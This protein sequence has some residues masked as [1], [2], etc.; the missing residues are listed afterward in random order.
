[1]RPERIVAALLAG[2]AAGLVALLIF[3]PTEGAKAKGDRPRAATPAPTTTAPTTIAT[4]TTEPEPEETVESKQEPT[5]TEAEPPSF[6][7]GDGTFSSPVTI[8]LYYESEINW[9]TH[10]L[11]SPV[12]ELRVEARATAVRGA[13]G[14]VHGIE[15]GLAHAT[16]TFLIDPWSGEY[17]VQETDPGSLTT[18]DLESGEAATLRTPPHPNVLSMTCAARAKS[19]FL[20]LR[21]NGRL[22]T[23]LMHGI[24][25]R[26][27]RVSVTAW[28]PEGGQKVVFDGV[29]VET[30]GS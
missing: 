8:N 25:G 18:I 17:V 20:S 15:C 24:G 11:Q 2:V 5:T 7:A 12:R 26:L 10:K 3:G 14:D 19:T 13:A 27:D 21:A 30:G 22:L 29:G 4:T 16:Y 28:S 9:R 6:L 1:M 23:S